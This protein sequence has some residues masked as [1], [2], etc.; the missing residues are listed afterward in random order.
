MVMLQEE[1]E[2]A[3]LPVSQF[4]WEFLFR[5]LPSRSDPPVV[6]CA[7]IPKIVPHS[8]NEQKC[9][10]ELLRGRARA[11]KSVGWGGGLDDRPH[12]ASRS[13]FP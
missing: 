6:N 10:G 8:L 11:L 9:I 4:G 13:P 3:T 7:P 12:P 5:R 2:G 1:G